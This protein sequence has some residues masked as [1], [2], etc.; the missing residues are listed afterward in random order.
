MTKPPAEDPK[1][2]ATLKQMALGAV[3]WIEEH[4]LD[5]LSFTLPPIDGSLMFI[6]PLSRAAVEM[7]AVNP[8]S[9]RF[10]LALDAA[11]GHEAT[12]TQACMIVRAMELPVTDWTDEFCA[13][14][15]ARGAKLVRERG[16][17]P[18]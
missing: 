9:R 4:G 12:A 14:L 5:G 6:A 16:G 1:Y 10:L 2:A 13:E 17:K 3:A 11:T 18:S 15:L 7:L 8:K